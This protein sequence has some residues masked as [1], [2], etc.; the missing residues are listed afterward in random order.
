MQRFIT[1]LMPFISA[2]SEYIAKAVADAGGAVLAEEKDLDTERTAERIIA[3][4]DD[5]EKLEAMS[6]ASLSC[7]PAG[8]TDKIYASIR[9]TLSE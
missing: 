6:R 7:S 1:V 2:F 9:E 5:S 3:L 8:A 4:K